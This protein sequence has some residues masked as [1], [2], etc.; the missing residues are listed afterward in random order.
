MCGAAA[1]PGLQAAHH[2][3][4]WRITASQANALW[5]P[6]PLALTCLLTLNCRSVGA[7]SRVDT[8]TQAGQNCAAALE[9]AR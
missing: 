8:T 3:A 7:R 2:L 6:P 9:V 4:G 5:E 1:P